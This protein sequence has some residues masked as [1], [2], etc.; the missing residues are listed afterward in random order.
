VGKSL[1]KRILLMV[2]LFG[3][4]LLHA[5][6]STSMP[7]QI[8]PEL[9]VY[10]RVSEK[11]RFYGVVSATRSNSEYTDGT[12]GGYVDYFAIPW[13]RGK[14]YFDLHD[15]TMGYYWW[16]R[17]GYSYSDAP[18]SDKK[19]VVNIFETETNNNFHLPEEI[20][21]Q[22]RNRLDWRWVN[23]DFQPIY[24]P[25][26]KFIRNFRTAYLTF[27]FYIWSEYFFY[28]NDNSQDKL[29]LTFGSVMKATKNMDIEIY[30]LHQFSNLPK[31]ASLDAVGLQLD[32][33]FRSKHYREALADKAKT[34]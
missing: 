6:D 11:V 22:T 16:F 3:P 17:M 14:K 9:D 25:R 10:Y 27:N 33:Y 28:L 34:P 30:Y 26:V 12:V 29:R 4:G 2:P 1:L 7:K 18:P 24:R 19:K 8:W 21:L 5:Q 32:F 13:L 15:T 31:V 20:V 23:G